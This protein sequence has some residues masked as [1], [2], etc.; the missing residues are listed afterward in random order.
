MSGSSGW[1]RVESLCNSNPSKSAEEKVIALTTDLPHSD[2][3]PFS[4]SATSSSN[5]IRSG[6]ESPIGSSRSSRRGG[7]D[8]FLSG[9]SSF[10][11]DTIKLVAN[12]KH[13]A[14]EN[15]RQKLLQLGWEIEEAKLNKL[16]LIAFEDEEKQRLKMADSDYHL[17]KKLLVDRDIP[18]LDQDVECLAESHDSELEDLA[19]A[20][21]QLFQ[22]SSISSLAT[23]YVS[24]RFPQNSSD[25][26]YEP[27]EEEQYDKYNHSDNSSNSDNDEAEANS[28]TSR[29]KPNPARKGFRPG[30]N[31]ELNPSGQPVITQL[32][33][34]GDRVQTPE[35]YQVQMN[36]SMQ[37]P[38]HS[39]QASTAPQPQQ[40]QLP[41]PQYLPPPP[42][43]HQPQHQPP[44][45][46]EPPP[47][48]QYQPPQQYEPPPQPQY[49]PLQ[50]Y[51]PLPQPQYQPLQQYEPPP[52]P[53]Y[54]PPQQ[55]EPPP[56]PQYQPP[57]QYQAHQR[58]EP[59]QH[60]RHEWNTGTAQSQAY[61]GAFALLQGEGSRLPSQPD[62]GSGSMAPWGVSRLIALAPYHVG[63]NVRGEQT[64][65]VIRRTKHVSDSG[66]RRQKTNL[67]PTPMIPVAN[68]PEEPAAPISTRIALDSKEVRQYKELAKEKLR[69]L[70]VTVAANTDGAPNDAMRN[71]MIETALQ[72]ARIELYGQVDIENIKGIHNYMVASL[73]DMRRALKVHALNTVPLG[74]SLRLPLFSLLD[75]AAHKRDTI[76]TLLDGGRYLHL[77]E[78]TVDDVDIERL[79][80]NEVLVNMVIDVLIGGWDANLEGPM[81]R[82]FA[83]CGAAIY[84]RF[85][86]VSVNSATFD[87][88]YQDI[89]AIVRTIRASDVLSARFDGVQQQVGL[90]VANH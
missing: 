30:V 8:L 39:H 12:A 11:D 84:C 68:A 74:Y 62:L 82:V 42:H 28:T 14:R 27:G 49:Q 48:P 3:V 34:L 73:A 47:P 31:S 76:Q 65:G 6:H 72:N 19:T 77:Y 80:E 20:D 64:Q 88:A 67:P 15:S 32:N 23:K 52:Q 71:T 37:H 85:T 7:R 44:Q 17:F 25:T 46:Y 16:V 43:Q 58:Y 13:A 89:M 59:Q 40:Y 57:Q 90:R 70:I 61:A 69:G 5:S 56:Q 33:L 29:R 54:Q 36:P 21:E 50:Q 87:D 26:E 35:Q 78:Q 10:S 1:T 63:E 86:D 18:A 2:S 41:V 79:L 9:L 22:M 4:R 83:S 45:Q 53:Q 24:H 60:Q 51:E 38:T 66:R 81:D 75:E 55:Y